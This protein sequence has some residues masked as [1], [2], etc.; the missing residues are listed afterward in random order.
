[1]SLLE[2]TYHLGS[3]VFARGFISF[4]FYG[5]WGV[6]SVLLL[7]CYLRPST[8][9]LR[10]F[11]FPEGHLSQEGKMCESPSPEKPGAEWGGGDQ[12]RVVDPRSQCRSLLNAPV[13][14]LG[15]F[16]V[17]PQC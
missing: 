9:I 14:A 16:I 17:M 12:S 3:Y 13:H 4:V 11:G 5:I 2:A 1:M 8:R 6:V 10:S 15:Q 7:L